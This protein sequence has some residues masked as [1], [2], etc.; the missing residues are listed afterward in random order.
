MGPGQG[1]PLL[2][3]L[4][5]HYGE[6]HELPTPYGGLGRSPSRKRS[7][8]IFLG[9]GTLLAERQNNVHVRCTA[10]CFV[11]PRTWTSEI[12][13]CSMGYWKLDIRR[14]SAKTG[15]GHS[16]FAGD[17]YGPPSPTA[18]AEN[19]SMDHGSWVKWF[20]KIGWVTWVMAH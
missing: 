3:R 6:R 14:C 17:T 1:C 10:C 2:N 5:D 13:R 7:F 11:M 4:G 9:H 8:D 18:R 20:M 19:G 16:G 15:G 12:W